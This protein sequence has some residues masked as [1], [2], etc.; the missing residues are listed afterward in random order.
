MSILTGKP[1]KR[2]HKNPR[3]KDTGRVATILRRKEKR[4]QRLEENKYIEVNGV[5]V[6]KPQWRDK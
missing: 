6:L 3:K 2:K 4:R 1:R 5:K